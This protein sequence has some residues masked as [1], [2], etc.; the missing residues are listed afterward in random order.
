ML[1][2]MRDLGT[3]ILGP[4]YFR[5][6]LATFGDAAHLIVVE[7]DGAPAGA[8]FLVEH[9]GTMYNPWSSSLRRFLDLR[10]NHVLYWE[11]LQL[12]IARGCARFDYGRSQWNSS[13]FVFKQ[14]WGATAVPLHYQYR[15]GRAAAPPTLAGHRRALEFAV[16]AWRRLPVPVAAVL[17]PHARRRFPEAL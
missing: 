11:A 17:G 12:A 15:L 16:R 14:Q 2:N 7:K 1:E 10:P 5:D 3:P 13:T 9:A 6:V 4:G 8:I